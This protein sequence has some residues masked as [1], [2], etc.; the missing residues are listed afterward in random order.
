MSGRGR[1]PP[2][3]LPGVC[4][5]GIARA[6]H[7]P[8]PRPLLPG[9]GQAGEGGARAT[10]AAAAPRPQGAG[11]GGGGAESRRG[12]VGGRREGRH[13]LR[14]G[15][16]GRGGGRAAPAPPSPGRPLARQGSRGG[17]RGGRRAAARLVGTGLPLKRGRRVG[18]HGG[19]RSGRAE[20]PPPPP[21][22]PALPSLPP[23]LPPE[24]PPARLKAPVGAAAVAVAQCGR[25]LRRCRDRGGAGAIDSQ[26][27]AWR[28]LSPSLPPPLRSRPSG[29]GCHRAARGAAAAPDAGRCQ[30]V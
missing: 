20:A 7:A 18:R 30:H 28:R 17:G 24:P 5:P 8:P 22:R 9:A 1:A 13:R 21:A 11:G 10:A 6:G 29:R 14:R 23:S 27:S 16:A 12:A 3:P 25:R 2:T 19:G 4:H 15:G 26:R